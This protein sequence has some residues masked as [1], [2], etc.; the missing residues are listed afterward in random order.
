ML[1][2][3]LIGC[4]RIGRKHAEI[5]SSNQVNGAELIAVCDIHSER[6]EEFSN[7][8]GVDGFISAEEMLETA[9]DRIDVLSILTPS[10]DHARNVL[11]TGKI[12]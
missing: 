3:A 9:G 4:G 7:R 11:T 6:S 10:G 2:F 5:L 12:P 1:R 8:F